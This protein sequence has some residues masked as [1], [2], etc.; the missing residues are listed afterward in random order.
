MGLEGSAHLYKPF[1][2]SLLLRDL[3][4]DLMRWN[5][6]SRKSV[7][8]EIDPHVY[9]GLLC[10]VRSSACLSDISFFFYSINLSFAAGSDCMQDGFVLCMCIVRT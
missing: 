4:S 1:S 2:P 7:E 5:S 3:Q 8:E 9:S 10:C 6:F